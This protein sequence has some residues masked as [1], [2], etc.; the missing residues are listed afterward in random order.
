[1]HLSSEKLVSKFAFEMGQLAPLHSGAPEQFVIGI[2]LTLK[3]ETYP[4]T[5]GLCTLE[6]S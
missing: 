2:A 5:V 6:S 4:Q 1:L 3:S